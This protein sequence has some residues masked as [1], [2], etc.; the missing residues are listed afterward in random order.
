MESNNLKHLNTN[1]G[2]LQY[3]KS[4]I[5]KSLNNIVKVPNL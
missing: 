3:S 1:D 2:K 4:S 5:S